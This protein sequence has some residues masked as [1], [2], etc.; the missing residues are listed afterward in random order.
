MY[1]SMYAQPDKDQL[2]YFVLFVFRSRESDGA[3]PE[4][5]QRK[6]D[7]QAHGPGTRRA[8][9]LPATNHGCNHDRS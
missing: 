8:S 4:V 7:Q 5:D 3:V 6:Q 9:R 2:V 1:I